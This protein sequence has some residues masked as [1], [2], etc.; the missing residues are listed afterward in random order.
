MDATD[1]SSQR[2]SS[3]RLF[4]FVTVRRT[5]GNL[6]MATNVLEGLN[7]GKI[8]CRTQES[9]GTLLDPVTTSRFENVASDSVPKWES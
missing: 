1:Q 9:L 2:A 4:S 8:L 3:T 7:W 5:I 6:P